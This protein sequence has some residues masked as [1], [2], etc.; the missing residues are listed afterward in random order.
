MHGVR[1]RLL[2]ISE[3]PGIVRAVR[4]WQVL[5]VGA[6]AAV[7]GVPDRIQLG[8]GDSDRVH[9]VRSGH[10]RVHHGSGVV[11]QLHVGS[12]HGR[13]GPGHV[14]HV[15][16]RQVLEPAGRRFVHGLPRR[17]LPEPVGTDD[18]QPVPGRNVY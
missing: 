11:L 13:Y 3:R 16:G 6:G 9:A 1:G 4:I 15:P 7:S 17:H 12:V 10:D 14:P 18:V 2:A 8:I 5:G